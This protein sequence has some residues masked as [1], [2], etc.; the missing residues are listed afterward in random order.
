MATE[1][2]IPADGKV[3]RILDLGCGDGRL[4]MALK[5]RFPE[6]EVWGLDCGGPMVR[7]AHMRATKL[8]NGA[9]FA[10]RLAEDTRFPDGYFDIVTSFLLFHEVSA[11]A[12]KQIIAETARILRPGGITTPGDI[13][14]PRTPMT[15][16]RQFFNWWNTRW[17]YEVWMLEHLATDYEKVFAANGFAVAGNA[18]TKAGG[19]M[20]LVGTKAG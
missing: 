5:E 4:T 12:N 20:N 19:T 9:N 1:H 13:R 14:I 8:G 7:F 3:R 10:Q 16:Y 17:N 15:G 11:A 18:R 2:P 6:A